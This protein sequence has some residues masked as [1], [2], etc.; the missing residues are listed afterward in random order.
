M[1][2]MTLRFVMIWHFNVLKLFLFINYFNDINYEML[3]LI[4][5]EPTATAKSF[6]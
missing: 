5:L 6:F 3:F 2:F 1:F 4:K